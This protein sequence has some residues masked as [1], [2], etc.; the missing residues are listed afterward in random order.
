MN[1]QIASGKVQMRSRAVFVLKSIALVFLSVLVFLT[2]T[3]IV[4]FII[5]SI[6]I[7]NTDAFLGFGPRGW[8]AFLIF[9]PWRL[10]VIDAL[11]IILLIMLLR[12]FRF[13]YRIPLL[14]MGGAVLIAATLF[15]FALERHTPMNDML[16]REANRPE[17]PRPIPTLFNRLHTPPPGEGRCHCEV[18]SITDAT[19]LEVRDVVT[20]EPFTAVIQDDAHGTTS[21]LKIGDMVFMGGEMHDGVFQVFGIRT[22]EQRGLRWH[23]EEKE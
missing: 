20:D 2:T 21:N 16:I 1:A 5:F 8:Y 11:G 4:N 7:Q 6:H 10:L 9:F 19:H 13:G 12:T 18:V 23:R 15:G 3:L 22:D 17:M 14:Y